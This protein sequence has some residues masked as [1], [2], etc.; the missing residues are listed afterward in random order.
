M[1]S[2]CLAVIHTSAAIILVAR[3]LEAVVCLT[4]FAHLLALLFSIIIYMR[5]IFTRFFNCKLLCR[6]LQKPVDV[7]HVG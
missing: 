6:F 3:E 5:N 1:F 4:Y 2:T 7:Y